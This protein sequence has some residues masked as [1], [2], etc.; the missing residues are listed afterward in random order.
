M[1]DSHY[2]LFHLAT[3]SF[4]YL[5]FYNLVILIVVLDACSSMKMFSGISFNI[6]SMVM[7][8]VDVIWA[9]TQICYCKVSKG[10]SEKSAFH[11]EL[12]VRCVR[13]IAEMSE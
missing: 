8:G 5:D 6:V 9:V 7:V 4:S 2:H 13:N 3:V 11:S 1:A 10:L 12:T